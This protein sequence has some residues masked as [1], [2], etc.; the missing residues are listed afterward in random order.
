MARRD[1]R[2]FALVASVPAAYLAFMFGQR[3]FFVRFA[4]VVLPFLSLLGGYGFSRIWDLIRVGMARRAVV[5]IF[6]AATLA[7]PLALSWQ[8]NV[9]LGREDTRAV[10]ANWIERE[11]SRGAAIAVESVSRMNS[12][13]GWKGS[14]MRS[15]SVFVPG[16][17]K[18]EE[19]LLNGSTDYVVV[20][21][22][23]Y[24]STRTHRDAALPVLY[25]RLEEVGQLE[26]VFAPGYGNSEVLYALDDAYSPFWHVFDRELPGPTVKIYRLQD[27][28]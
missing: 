6:A 5:P 27:M 17:P 4:I 15:T 8:H 7:Q 11:T 14:Q 12:P 18:D 1:V 9:L 19:E 24:A 13:F 28:E 2:G 10:A 22:F 23:G 26:V 25:Q 20:T 16:S 3:L 21:S